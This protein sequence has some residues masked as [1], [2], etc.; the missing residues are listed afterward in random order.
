MRTMA[1]EI[2]GTLVHDNLSIR[3]REIE[4]Q[5]RAAINFDTVLF[6]FS[7]CTYLSPIGVLYLVMRRD[8]LRDLGIETRARIPNA[9]LRKFIRAFRIIPLEDVDDVFGEYALGP[10]R[11]MCIQDCRNTHSDIFVRLVNR[12]EWEAD[13]LAAVDYM[14][15][16]IWDNSGCHGY[17]CYETDTYPKPVYIAAF[18]YRDRIE[19]AIGDRGQGFN[20]SLS[21]NNKDFALADPRETLRMAV[22]NNVSG[23]PTG[24]PGFGLFAAS[25]FARTGGKLSIWSDGLQLQIA[26]KGDKLIK[27]S[28]S[29]GTMTSIVMRKKSKIPFTSIV[30]THQNADEY[31]EEMLEGV[32]Q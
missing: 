31:I 32:F 27:G 21:E 2:S 1:V 29:G 19:I 25:S 30:Q 6:D 4:P 12:N 28:L 15:N 8:E 22:K 5:I 10:N 23:H 3:L 7:K 14:L 24:S 13:A 9:G 20:K 17:K 26:D 18:S 11:C 16:E